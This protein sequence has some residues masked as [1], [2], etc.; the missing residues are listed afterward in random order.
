MG[1][2]FKFIYDL[3]VVAI[4]A[5]FAFVGLKKG[6]AKV[7]VGLVSAVVAFALAMSL[8][9][10]ITEKLYAAK[11]QK[12]VEEQFASVTNNFLPDFEL[13]AVANIDFSKVRIGGKAASD[14]KIDYAGT[15]KAI[16]DLS[17]LDLY[18]T[19]LKEEDLR[20]I[21]ITGDINLRA[22][23]GKT[24]EFTKD[25]IERY[26]LGK[27]SAAQYIAVSLVNNPAFEDFDELAQKVLKYI[28]SISSS[29][30]GDGMGVSAL[31][32]IALK[33]FETKGNIKDT[34]M[35]GIIEPYCKLIIRT[36]VF[37]LIITIV[38]IILR[39]VTSALKLVNKIPV[40]G[41][42]NSI[43]GLVLGLAEGLIVVFGLC[44]IIRVVVA[45]SGANSILFNSAAIDSTYVFKWF[46]NFDFLNFLN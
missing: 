11:I 38:D 26:G 22:L 29:A 17:T 23:N 8:S 42:V 5:V 44:L 24:A 40:I 7:V 37:T 46:Y 12:P 33:M 28:P 21:G 13:G 9:G 6:F 14:T 16:L 41:K 3:A 43:L 34:V 20:K 32:T 30:A 10:P 4:L 45:M 2:E 18:D 31:R 1:Q 19:G 36:L 25:D 27:L 35:N 15:G 39:I